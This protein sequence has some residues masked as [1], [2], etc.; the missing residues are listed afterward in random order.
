MH[1]ADNPHVKIKLKLGDR[2]FDLC[3]LTSFSINIYLFKVPT[4]MNWPHLI[5]FN[6]VVIV[7]TYLSLNLAF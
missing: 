4:C 1:E 3:F 7:G 6:K 5:F 2:V